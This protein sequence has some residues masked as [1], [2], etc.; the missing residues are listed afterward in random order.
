M[1]DHEQRV[2]AVPGYVYDKE[3]QRNRLRR[4]EGQI[5][6]LQRMVEADTYCIDV[7]TQVSAAT[8]AMEKVALDLLEEHLRHCVVHAASDQ[9]QLDDQVAVRSHRPARPGLTHD[10]HDHHDHDHDHEREVQAWTRTPTSC[11]W[12]RAPAAAAARAPRPPA[13]RSPRT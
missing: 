1:T 11:P 12:R 6:G 10:H 9:V 3:A 4:I 5:R 8:K 2:R 13:R 7:L